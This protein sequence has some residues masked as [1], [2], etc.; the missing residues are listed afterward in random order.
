ME[1]N[2]GLAGLGTIAKTHLLGLRNIP[3]LSIDVPFSV[4]FHILFSS[5]PEQNAVLAKQI[6]FKTV[7][8]SM[9][10]LVA[11][12]ELNVVDIC[13]PNFLHRE[14][15]LTAMKAGKHVYCEKPLAVN[16]DETAQMLQAATNTQVINQV[17]FVM[18]FNPA[19]A[20]AHSAIK[21]GV[22]GKPYAFRG[23]ILHSSYLPVEKPMTWRLEKSKSGGGALVDLGVHLIDLVRFLLG[24]VKMVSCTTKTVVKERQRPNGE[25][26]NVDVDDWASLDLQV[27]SGI[28]GT[29]EASRLAVGNDASRLWIYGTNGSLLIDLNHEPYA[30]TFYNT[31]GQR[32]YVDTKTLMQDKFYQNVTKLYPPAKLSQGFM[33]D[34]HLTSLLWFLMGVSDGKPMDDAPT[35]M[36]G[37]IAQLIIEAAYKSDEQGHNFIEIL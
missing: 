37:H 33:V 15:A 9:E 6:G 30:P 36:D 16:S 26:G 19:V 14:Q 32:I 21:Q 17:A 28:S 10:K 20:A 18:R 1:I 24:D 12:S 4:N 29:I 35:F 34:T 3:L 2:Y 11:S 13:T 7:V 31:Y 23:E 22:I 25:I 27:E 5:H 8:D